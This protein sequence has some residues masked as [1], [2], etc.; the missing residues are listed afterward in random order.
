MIKKE[1]YILVLFLGILFVPH[2][3]YAQVDFNKT[4][5]DDLGDN[6]DEFQEL[7]YE[8]L[9][10][11]G[12][13]NYDRSAEAFLKCIALDD[14]VPVLYFELGKNYNKLNNFSDA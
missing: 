11:K 9:K 2:L 14:A 10:Q 6:A 3:N 7:F 1:F 12:I 4:P 13:E 5:D 8:A